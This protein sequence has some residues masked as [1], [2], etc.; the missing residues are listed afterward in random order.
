M[1]FCLPA[2]LLALAPLVVGLV[3]FALI[4]LMG[5]YI[6]G[7]SRHVVDNQ[8]NGADSGLFTGLVILSVIA[9]VFFAAI[10]ILSTAG[11]CSSTV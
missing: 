3:L 6:W 5:F 8:H 1:S 2:W 10:A 11:T 7:V 9:L 4:V